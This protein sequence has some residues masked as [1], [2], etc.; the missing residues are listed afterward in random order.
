MLSILKERNS[1]IA[2]LRLSLYWGLAAAC[3]VGLA[4]LG[5]VAS[6]SLSLQSIQRVEVAEQSA[7]DTRLDLLI[8]KELTDLSI[9]NKGGWAVWDD[10]YKFAKDGNQKFIDVN[11]DWKSSLE[12]FSG[13]QF[14]YVLDTAGRVV[15]G[16]SYNSNWGGKVVLPEVP[17]DSWKKTRL[18][19]QMR[20]AGASGLLVTERGLLF[21]Q[22]SAILSSSNNRLPAR[23]CLVIGRFLNGK[24]SDRFDA[25]LE[26]HLLTHRVIND[27][28]PFDGITIKELET[29]HSVQ[30]NDEGTS[31]RQYSLR[32]SVDGTPILLEQNFPRTLYREGHHVANVL[33]L[34]VFL[35]LTGLGFV[36]LISFVAYRNKSRKK[37]AELENCVLEATRELRVAETRWYT[38]VQS[39]GN[40]VLWFDQEGR[41][42]YA[43]PAFEKTFTVKSSMLVDSFIHDVLYH[44]HSQ[45]GECC[46]LSA[47]RQGKVIH[48]YEDLLGK[49]S[50]ESIH[51]STTIVPIHN[52]YG[53]A[54]ALAILTD[55]SERVSAD[56]FLRDGEM[57]FR[58]MF[59]RMD[60]GVMLLRSCDGGID[61]EITDMNPAGERISGMSL[62]DSV[63]KRFSI[64]F[65][66]MVELHILSTLQKVYQT[67]SPES[68]PVA[69]LRTPRGSGWCRCFVYRVNLE[70]S[71]LIL[72]DETERMESQAALQKSEE[73]LRRLFEMPLIGVCTI[74]VRGQ[75]L[76][77][78]NRLSE[79]LGYP[80]EAL[81]K[82]TWM[83][84]TPMED[85]KEGAALFND[86]IGNPNS[87]KREF[88]R[89]F[90]HRAGHIIETRI[91]AMVVHNA[92][93]TPEDVV[94]LIED[95]TAKV[96]LDRVLSFSVVLTQRSESAN[97]EELFGAGIS[98]AMRM[99]ESEFAFV[100]LVQNYGR[101]FEIKAVQG[102]NQFGLELHK[103]DFDDDSVVWLQ[104]IST[105]RPV[106][107]NEF[108]ILPA[109]LRRGLLGPRVAI[110]RLLLI[111]VVDQ[112]GVAM[113]VGLANK[114]SPYIPLDVRITEMLGK[115]LWILLRRKYTEQA[116]RESEI[117]MRAMFDAV[118]T[119]IVLIDADTRRI[120]DANPVSVKMFGGTRADL[121]GK[122]CHCSISARKEKTCPL[123]DLHETVENWESVFVCADGSLIPV[124]KTVTRVEISGRVFLL[125]SI[126]DVSER[127]IF[128]AKLSAEKDA[129][130]AANR[131]KSN[132]LANMSHEIRTPLNGVIGMNNLL[133]DTKLDDEQRRYAEMAR[134]SADSLLNLINDVL[135]LSKIEAERIVLEKFDFDLRDLFD[136]MA[137]FFAH[138]TLSKSLDFMVHLP[139]K[140]PV[141][142]RGDYVRLRQVLTN[143]LGNAVKFTDAGY[144]SLRA[145]LESETET[146][147]T[148]RLEVHDSGIGIDDK[149][150][151]SLFEPFT[152]ADQTTT[153]KFGGTGL[154]LSICKRL[155][156]LMEGQIGLESTVGEGSTFWFTIPFEK[157]AQLQ[158]PNE[159]SP[160]AILCGLTIQEQELLVDALWYEG[161]NSLCVNEVTEDIGAAKYEFMPLGQTSS[162]RNEATLPIFVVNNDGDELALGK[163]PHKILVCKPLRYANLRRCLGSVPHR[164]NQTRLVE[165]SISQITTFA[166]P[167]QILLVEDNIVNQRVAVGMLHKLGVEIIIANNGEEAISCLQKENY[168]LV[169]MD[170]QMP[171]L[172]GY[173]ATR[174][175]R[176]GNAGVLD[177][178][179]PIIAMTANALAG[180]RERCLECGMNDYLSK[181]FTKAAM[182]KILA[183]WIKIDRI[184]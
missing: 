152:Q 59:E 72:N 104:C 101:S 129:A 75:F 36:L 184:K 66:N 119:G 46:L 3:I 174:K 125:E 53:V 81:M 29:H 63:G 122:Q 89:R 183:S 37:N 17:Q 126:I 73:R 85:L 88:M 105:R 171:V 21:L 49:T 4:F 64:L 147:A 24:M 155:V 28:V 169:L 170:C 93:G 14:F 177:V 132:F 78:N 146:K 6:R 62:K 12:S 74:S 18:W 39:S 95:V 180:D 162:K 10:L 179:V 109:Q 108:S 79:I 55:I 124:L 118:Q 113:I 5:A 25:L 136:E 135:D 48:V 38:L 148:I 87:S 144:I 58:A 142:L 45:S 7:R 67:G 84:R 16:G 159:N 69:W 150:Q 168:D 31:A 134:V 99:T 57:R 149:A 2:G 33:F 42:I 176:S 138:T 70:E 123:L 15:W 158:E 137:D 94:C 98:E 157:R 181:P 50:E 60:S 92:D 178:N 182:E 91:S 175:I 173:S 100:G 43:N 110:Q 130:E 65:P 77:A 83:D 131:A 172:D 167:L 121:I 30:I 47:V 161:V 141:L 111:P 40:P 27:S 102:A 80:L 166:G 120:I 20:K 160:R 56:Q 8:E 107:Q 86:L 106:V 51:V 22:S 140:L 61:F 97:I 26:A 11:L 71:V 143:L 54:G 44:P 133:L 165:D 34:S 103:I 154:G 128:E 9:I 13:I 1:D 164:P 112:G 19:E 23:G 156:E 32:T 115:H 117:R 96:R 114:V 90:R 116:L 82:M 35:G 145:F 68:L 139:A 52:E 153:R 41:I 76:S 127:K 151:T 163:L